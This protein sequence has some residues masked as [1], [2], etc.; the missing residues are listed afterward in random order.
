MPRSISFFLLV[1]SFGIL[2]AGCTPSE[3]DKSLEDFTFTE[4]D[5][6]R[7]AEIAGSG[8]IDLTQ[9]SST[10]VL[11]VAQNTGSSVLT[12][13]VAVTKN[14]EKQ[15][16]Y[17][18]LRMA[19]QDQGENLYKVN[20][21]FLN[22]RV[23]MDVSSELVR[24]L[25]QGEVLTVTEIPNAG[26]AKVKL[27]D[28]KE[29]YV[30]FRYIA[31][32][33]TEAKLPDEK[34]KFEGQYFVDFQ[35]LNIR[36]DPSS[37]AEKIGELPGEAILKPISMSGEW[38]RV[39]HD[40]K[41]GYVSSQ[42]LKPFLPAFLVRQD[43]YAVSILQYQ[44][45]DS[46]SIAAL[47]KHIAA[48]KNAGKKVVTLKA[49]YDTVLAQETR[50]ARISPDMVILTVVGVSAKNVRAVSDALDGAG[51]G[52]TIFLRTKDIGLSGITEKMILNLLANGNDLQSSGHTGDDL[53][54][55][56]DAQVMLEFGQSKKL[57]ED[58]SKREVSSFAY[59][60]GGVNDRIMKLASEYG[61]LFGLTQTPDR[62]FTRAQFLRLPSLYV[63]SGMTADDIVKLAQ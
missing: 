63:T 2:F 12:E 52:A 42:Y 28:G 20:N 6:E 44:A 8:A 58:I 60:S 35:F 30:A 27:G 25:G 54:S 51:V 13:T 29:G 45:D 56:T 38:A 31:K 46:A 9:P 50:D 19:V 32:L 10:E 36:K 21:P 24:R 43:D 14:P 37:Q 17:D 34:K 26:W 39:A 40:G 48:L 57:I 7:V 4:S 18:S 16:F 47:G 53:R 15:A 33:V 3:P 61:Y 41:E 23:S 59:P 49:L 11:S 1:V 62:K 22:V 5:L 55:M